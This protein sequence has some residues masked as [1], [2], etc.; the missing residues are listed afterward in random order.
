MNN[1][2]LFG[3]G[4]VIAL[5][6]GLFLKSKQTKPIEGID[7]IISKEDRYKNRKKVLEEAITNKEWDIVQSLYNSGFEGHEDL[8]QIAKNAL[9]NK[10][11]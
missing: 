4:V 11:K 5:G 3:A 8:M 7:D 1:L 6:V 10:D 2:F 9:D